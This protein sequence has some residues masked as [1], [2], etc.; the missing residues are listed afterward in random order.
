MLAE[1]GKNKNVSC[2]EFLLEVSEF[3]K[4][5]GKITSRAVKFGPN[6]D[7]VMVDD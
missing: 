3:C 2:I 7:E 6:S 5:S 1:F 4:D